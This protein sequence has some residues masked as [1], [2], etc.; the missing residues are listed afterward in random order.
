MK[1]LLHFLSGAYSAFNPVFAIQSFPK[2]IL[3]A[4]SKY[5][6]HMAKMI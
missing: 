4:H 6:L 1:Q 2:R 5:S 3:L